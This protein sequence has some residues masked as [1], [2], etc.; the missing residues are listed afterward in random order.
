MSTLPMGVVTFLLSDVEDSTRLWLAYREKMREA[1]E[2]HDSLVAAFVTQAGGI[3]VKPRGEGDSHF[4]VFS[5]PSSAVLASATLQRA[6][7]DERWAGGVPLRIRMAL[8]TGETDVRDDDYYGLA[9]SRCGRLRSIA[10]GGQIVLSNATAELVIDS[11]PDG[12]TLRSLG[13]HELRGLGRPERIWQLCGAGLPEEFPP[14]ASVGPAPHDLVTVLVTDVVGLTQLASEVGNR[15]TRQWLDTHDDLVKVELQRFGGRLWLITEDSVL[16]SFDSARRALDCARA[17]RD[18]IA[19]LGSALRV[20]VHAGEVEV[21]G[22]RL[23]GLAVHIASRISSRAKGGEILVSRTVFDLL[24][25]SD[26]SLED[27]G[28]FE[29]RGISGLWRVYALSE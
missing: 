1:I 9:P 29:L 17:L 5:R 15:R 4:T 13:T 12:L 22:D 19:G 23:H 26:I 14:L 25:G 6:L 21:R 2:R 16:A 28:D 7:T 24:A 3:L 8:H 18:G 20:G 10:H 11:L 27:R